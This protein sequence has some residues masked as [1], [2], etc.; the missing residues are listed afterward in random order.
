M[1]AAR[2]GHKAW[3]YLRCCGLAGAMLCGAALPHAAEACRASP[4]GR[5]S[6]VQS[7]IT[8]H[9]DVT[10]W[11]SDL[12]NRYR[13][14]VLGDAS[15]PTALHILTK[16]NRTSC[17][18][19]VVLERPHVFEDIAPRLF[20]VDQ[21]GRLDLITIRSHEQKG[22]QIAIYS[23]DL[24]SG[25][26][27]LL[28]TTPYIGTAHR[29]LAP[30]GVGDLDGDGAIEIA[31]VDRPHL[32]KTLRVWRFENNEL[33]EVAALRGVTN[34]RIGEDFITGGLRDCGSG[35]E[36]IL[37]DA[38]WQNIL[39]VQFGANVLKTTAIGPFTGQPSIKAALGCH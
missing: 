22:A 15:E 28:A 33:H 12:T 6:V 14:G 37:V 4:V 38:R 5:L 26:L 36:M 2:L 11:Y 23:Q 29:W 21:D 13:H 17:G 34:H 20:D 18:Y 16:A 35:T 9:G 32:A 19:S 25:S 1:N 31:F 7:S 24:D 10:A 39:S 27:T 3:Q 8:S 30:A